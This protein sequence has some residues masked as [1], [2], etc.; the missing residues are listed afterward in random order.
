MKLVNIPYAVLFIA[1][2]TA[3]LIICVFKGANFYYLSVF[4]PCLSGGIVFIVHKYKGPPKKTD[5]LYNW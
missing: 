4:G 2:F 1:A 5:N 3:L